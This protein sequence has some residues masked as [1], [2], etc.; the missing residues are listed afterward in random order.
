MSASRSLY[1]SAG[2]QAHTVENVTLVDLLDRLLAGGVIVQG[3]L[4]LAAADIDL[5][6]VDLA[7]LIASHDRVT[8]PIPAL[9]P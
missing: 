5:V 8:S 9:A 1:A 2:M 6:D 4:R 7:L 3:H